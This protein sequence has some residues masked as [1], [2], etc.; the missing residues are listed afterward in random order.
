MHIGEVSVYFENTCR[1]SSVSGSV[2]G[3]GERGER[4]RGG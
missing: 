4:E 1:A 2:L 3:A